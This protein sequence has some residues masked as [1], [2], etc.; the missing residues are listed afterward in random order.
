MFLLF[1]LLLQIIFLGPS[2]LIWALCKWFFSKY[3]SINPYLGTF[4]CFLGAI[5]TAFFFNIELEGGVLSGI[6]ISSLLSFIYSLIINL[7]IVLFNYIVARK[8][9]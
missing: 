8:N 2:L 4:L 5:A 7:G 1:F 9:I 6:V 3:I